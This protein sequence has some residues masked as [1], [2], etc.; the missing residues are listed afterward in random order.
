M[1]FLIQIWI[2]C[3]FYTAITFSNFNECDIFWIYNLCNKKEAQ[4]CPGNSCKIKEINENQKVG[5][6]QITIL[7]I[8]S[9]LAYLLFS[10]SIL[11][12]TKITPIIEEK[13]E[14]KLENKIETPASPTKEI[15][16][17]CTPPQWAID[18]GYGEKWKLHHGCK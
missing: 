5:I 12:K 15:N 10:S 8:F 2:Y 17:D 14:I 16:D 11:D 9:S 18:M 1:W 4:N 3:K 13:Q 7:M 6:V